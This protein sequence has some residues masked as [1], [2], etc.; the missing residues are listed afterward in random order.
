MEN[1]NLQKPCSG[2]GKPTAGFTGGK[3]LCFPCYNSAVPGLPKPKEDIMPTELKPDAVTLEEAMA[4][5]RKTCAYEDGY[6]ENAPSIS[7]GNKMVNRYDRDQS[8]FAKRN[9]QNDQ[10]PTTYPETKE[11]VIIP[12]DRPEIPLAYVMSKGPCRMHVALDKNGQ[13][14]VNIE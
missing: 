5:I 1:D 10:S 4:F 8:D 7:D 3:P 14:R 11:E 9:G 13:I 12:G 6:S 2:C